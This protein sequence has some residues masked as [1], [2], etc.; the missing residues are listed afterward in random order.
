VPEENSS[1]SPFTDLRFSN[2][3][4]LLLAVSEGRVYVLDAFKGEVRCCFCGG[5]GACG[6]A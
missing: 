5:F 4:N 6:V 2:D 3:G 1:P